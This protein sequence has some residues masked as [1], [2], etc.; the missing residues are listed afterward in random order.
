M[1]KIK[2]G[3]KS[4]EITSPTCGKGWKR[5][6]PCLT[7][8]LSVCRGKIPPKMENNNNNNNKF[9]QEENI[10]YFGGCRWMLGMNLWDIWGEIFWYLESAPIS[11]KTAFYKSPWN[12]GG[13]YVSFHPSFLDIM[14]TEHNNFFLP[15]VFLGPSPA[16]RK[17]GSWKAWKR[18]FFFSIFFFLF[19]LWFLW[20][21]DETYVVCGMHDKIPK[22][23]IKIIIQKMVKFISK[24]FP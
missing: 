17:P 8:I 2:C 12:W 22:I 16:L 11:N 10:G 3:T 9:W 24:D 1:G 7:L 20:T 13:T 15:F 19:F 18:N 14:N 5:C 21:R 6:G 23:K 4:T